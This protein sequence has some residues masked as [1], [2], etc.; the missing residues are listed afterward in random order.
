MAARIA[1]V[2]N[3]DADLELAAASDYTPPKRVLEATRQMVPALAAALLADGDLLVDETSAK[4]AARGMVG[5]AFCPTP[6]AVALLERAGAEV[7]PHPSLAVLRKVNARAFCAALGPTMPGASFVDDVTEAM[8]RIATPPPVG[9]GWRVKRNFGMTGRR[10]RI[11]KPGAPIVADVAFIEGGVAE[12]GVQIEPNV[13]IAAEYAIH[14]FLR[15]NGELK[16]G[17]LVVQECDSLGRWVAT[18]PLSGAPA[19]AEAIG[20]EARMLDEGRTVARALV[21]AGYFGPFGVDGYSYASADGELSLQ[22]RSEINARYTM[23]YP[24]GMA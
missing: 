5:R 8:D 11:V 15:Q 9:D 2:L 13:S 16:A 20:V 21:E 22:T 24:V 7:E 12:G 17:R 14:G 4:G 1:W 10:Q 3:L 19:A 6:R 18:R 23:G